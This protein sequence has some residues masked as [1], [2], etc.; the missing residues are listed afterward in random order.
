MYYC[1]KDVTP[2][3]GYR[4]ELAFEDGKRGVF[5][6]SRYLDWK[7]FKP[8]RVPAVFARARALDGTVV[9]PG[10]IDI[11]PERLYDECEPVTNARALAEAA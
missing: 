7:L 9:W 8:L 1:V 2:L 6:M 3:E 11:S 5:D 10:D 4:I